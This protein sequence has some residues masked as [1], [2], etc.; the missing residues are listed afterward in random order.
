MTEAKKE[1]LHFI[2]IG[3][4]ELEFS[5]EPASPSVLTS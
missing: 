5:M 1:E 2:I 3:A 4:G